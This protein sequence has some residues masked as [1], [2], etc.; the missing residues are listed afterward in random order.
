MRL[1]WHKDSD[2]T[3]KD[4]WIHW[5]G[6]LEDNPLLGAFLGTFA[7]SRPANS[8]VIDNRFPPFGAEKITKQKNVHSILIFLEK[9]LSKNQISMA[10][11]KAMKE[12]PVA[13]GAMI[14]IADIPQ[15]EC[16][17]Y[18]EAFSN[19]SFEITKYSKLRLASR[20]VLLSKRCDVACFKK[21]QNNAKLFSFESKLN[22]AASFCDNTSGMGKDEPTSTAELLMWI[23]FHDSYIFWKYIGRNR[24]KFLYLADN[25]KWKRTSISKVI[26]I[27]QK[28][29]RSP[30]YMTF[31]VMRLSESS[32]CL[33]RRL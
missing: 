4:Y 25:V 28:F 21:S 11:E 6:N 7:N 2:T 18:I 14:F 13:D 12:I 27:L 10:I 1:S 26:L 24:R 19:G 30:S 22:E 32:G 23:R 20:I 5:E 9:G 8:I 17:T 3:D 33:R 15:Y 16:S 31:F 29:F